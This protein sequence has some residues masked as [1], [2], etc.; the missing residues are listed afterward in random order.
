[1]HLVDPSVNMMGT[2]AVV[3]SSISE[4]V[5]YAMGVKY[6]GSAEVVVCFFGDGATD[7]GVFHESLNF[8]SLKK[9]PILFVC[10]NN[11]YSVFSPQ[12]KRQ[13]GVEIYEKVKTFGKHSEKIF[14][15]NCC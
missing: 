2:S 5:G 9:L 11:N 12:K 3:A 14:G 1:M 6:K 4:A 8:A 15:N 10:E 13:A 7:Q